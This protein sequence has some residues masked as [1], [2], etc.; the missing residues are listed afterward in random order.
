MGKFRRCF[1]K[2]GCRLGTN[3]LLHI[4]SFLYLQDYSVATPFE[5]INSIVLI[6]YA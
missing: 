2:N 6:L 5:V 4:F 3:D 1:S